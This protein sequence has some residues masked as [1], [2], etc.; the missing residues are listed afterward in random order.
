[1]WR[2]RFPGPPFVFVFVRRKKQKKLF[3]DQRERPLP[4]SRNRDVRKD[5][6]SVIRA[7]P[8]KAFD[9]NKVVIVGIVEIQLSLKRIISD[10]DKIR[11]IRKTQHASASVIVTLNTN[12]SYPR[13]RFRLNS[14]II[15]KSARCMIKTCRF[16]FFCH[17]YPFGQMFSCVS[18]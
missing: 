12:P 2:F 15:Y 18:A 4:Y 14:H 1:M 17:N 9:C 5:Y 13:R 6:C 3:S 10:K 8:L 11:L 16:F 7:G